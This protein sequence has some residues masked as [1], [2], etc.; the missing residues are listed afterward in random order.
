M[1]SPELPGLDVELINDVLQARNLFLPCPILVD[2]VVECPNH[3]DASEAVVKPFDFG[4]QLLGR[5][6][7]ATDDS[8]GPGPGHVLQGVLTRGP[9]FGLFQFQRGI[10]N[11]KEW[12]S[13]HI[14]NECW[15]L[16]N[17]RNVVEFLAGLVVDVQ[18]FYPRALWVNQGIHV[19]LV[20]LCPQLGALQSGMDNPGEVVLA[21]N[22]GHSK[23]EVFHWE[24]EFHCCAGR[25]VEMSLPRIHGEICRKLDR[26]VRHFVDGRRLHGAGEDLT[27][28]Y[29]SRLAKQELLGSLNTTGCGLN[30]MLWFVNM[31]VSHII[32]TLCKCHVNSTSKI[33]CIILCQLGVLSCTWCMNM[34]F[35][36]SL[37]QVSMEMFKHMFI[38]AC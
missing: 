8:I 30:R 16:R 5:C 24:E 38:C 13:R 28:A 22:P 19:R 32:L 23:P 4:Q 35:A 12:I 21:V 26:Y 34:K 9:T 31:Y 3:V 18:W 15:S 11:D 17:R 27:L 6:P 33:I 2:Q 20:Q 1:A 14:I 36:L 29:L 10:A 25:E 37:T 7:W